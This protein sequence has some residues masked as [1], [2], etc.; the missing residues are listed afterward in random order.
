[1]TKYNLIDKPSVIKPTYRKSLNQG[2]IT[3][4][5]L[6]YLFRFASSEQI[7]T[8]S[9][10]KGAKAVQKRL[11]ILE[12]QGLIAKR[13]DKSYKL[14]GKPAA[15]YLQPHGARLL[16]QLNPKRKSDDPTNI[17]RLYRNKDVSESFIE[18]CLN[19]LNT[20]LTLKALNQVDDQLNF[21]PKIVL[22]G[23]DYEDFPHPLPDAYIGLETEKG[24][25]PFFLDLFEA[26][27]PFFVLVRRI[28][29]YLDY[30]D[31]DEWPFDGNLP[32]MLIIVTNKS[33]HKRL[34]KRIARDLQNADM[35]TSFAT[36][37]LSHLQ[38]IEHDGKVWLPINEDGDDPEDPRKPHR[39]RSLS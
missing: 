21:I 3:V 33:I 6:L 20:Y 29:K 19:T 10:V 26:N 5:N 9:G 15:Y 36:T 24:Y 31:H 34:R 39:L 25:Q 13:Y 4:L 38:N 35:E 11:K 23:E 7:A 8:Y 37:E 1:M 17:K 28:K 12:E 27:Q 2:Q 32:I 16:A 14:R 18:H 22:N 30:A